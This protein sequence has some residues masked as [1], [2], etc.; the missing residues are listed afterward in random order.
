MT[1]Y[2]QK[3]SLHKVDSKIIEKEW[4]S[5]EI[6]R[7]DEYC[8]KKMVLKPKYKCSCHFHRDKKESFIL[9]EGGLTIETITPEGDKNIVTLTD[10]YESFTLEPNVPHMFYCPD[11]QKEDTVFIEA[12]TKDNINDS[13]RI[14]RSGKR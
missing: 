4:G 6:I 10:K 9:I 2:Y 8:V 14:T 13:F 7:N 1:H 11:K 3:R 5:E 12:S